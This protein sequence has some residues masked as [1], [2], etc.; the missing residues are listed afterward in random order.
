[1]KKPLKIKSEFALLD[2]LG[3]GASLQRALTKRGGV[4]VTIKGRITAIWGSHD[5]TSQ[6]YQMLV[7]SIEVEEPK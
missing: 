3:S 2:V 7:Q 6:E 4:P 1:M 5:G